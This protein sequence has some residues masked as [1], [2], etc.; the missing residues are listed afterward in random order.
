MPLNQPF[1]VSAIVEVCPQPWR[2]GDGC[3]EETA[4]PGVEE[5]GR[6]NVWSSKYCLWWRRAMTSLQSQ[7]SVAP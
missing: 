7:E 5:A 6:Q 4:G 1:A 2:T 3:T